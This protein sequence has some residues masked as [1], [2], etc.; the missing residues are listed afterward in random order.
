MDTIVQLYD[1]D[2]IIL[3]QQLQL[4]EKHKKH[5]Q[6]LTLCTKISFRRGQKPFQ[7][8]S[9][10]VSGASAAGKPHSG[11]S[12]PRLSSRQTRLQRN[13]YHSYRVNATVFVGWTC[14]ISLDGDLKVCYHDWALYCAGMGSEGSAAGDGYSDPS[15]WQLPGTATGG[16][17]RHKHR[18]FW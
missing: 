6:N 13:I 7:T 1:I 5:C 17:G 9:Q 11:L 3:F 8:P 10:A 15:E 4:D 14:L 2:S 12:S 16:I 18:Y